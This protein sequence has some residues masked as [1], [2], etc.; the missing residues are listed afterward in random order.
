MLHDRFAYTPYRSST[1]AILSN[2]NIKR[3]V[4]YIP[5]STEALLNQYLT[6]IINHRTSK[7]RFSLFLNWDKMRL[8]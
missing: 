6:D 4:P 7:N 5:K 8:K 1:N 3:H 2:Q